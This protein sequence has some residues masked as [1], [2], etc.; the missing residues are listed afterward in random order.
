MLQFLCYTLPLP[1]PLLKAVL[2]DTLDH[3]DQPLLQPIGCKEARTFLPPQDLTSF[4]TPPWPSPPPSRSTVACFQASMPSRPPWRLGRAWRGWYVWR[5]YAPATPT[6]P[7]PFRC[8][9]GTAP[10]PATV[11]ASHKILCAVRRI[12]PPCMLCR[13]RNGKT[14]SRLRETKSRLRGFFATCKRCALLH[15]FSRH[16]YPLKLYHDL[17]NPKPQP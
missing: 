15:A 6:S 2:L 17:G 12:G 14:K 5:S 1:A 3:P 13:K 9:H 10:G 7:L 4:L 11:A 16:L 8:S